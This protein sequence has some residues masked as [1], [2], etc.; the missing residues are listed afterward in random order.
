MQ[1]KILQKMGSF[2]SD[3]TMC[4]GIECPIRTE[5]RRYTATP[6]KYR[7][8]YFSESPGAKNED[9]VFSCDMFWGDNQERIYKQTEIING[10]EV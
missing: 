8:S 9:G 3:F 2:G 7:Q 4:E 5:C 1:N 10:E 6:N